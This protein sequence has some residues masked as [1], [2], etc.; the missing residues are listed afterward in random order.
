MPSLVAHFSDSIYGEI[1]GLIS[2]FNVLLAPDSS[3]SLELQS[4]GL[5]ASEN[6][7]FSIDASLDAVCLLV[8][9]ED[10]VSDG[11]TL[12]LYCQKL[13]IWYGTFIP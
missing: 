1:M 13:G 8:N 12:N 9:L 3:D 2:H 4:N 7:W 10:N 11:Y 6:T 5:R